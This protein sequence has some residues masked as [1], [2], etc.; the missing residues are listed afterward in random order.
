[1]LE[2]ARFFLGSLLLHLVLLALILFQAYQK[3]PAPY[4]LETQV[5]FEQAAPTK[6]PKQIARD[7]RVTAKKIKTV[8]KEKREPIKKLPKKDGFLRSNRLLESPARQEVESASIAGVKTEGKTGGSLK[9][10]AK[11]WKTKNER[12]AYRGVLSRL[13][14]ANWVLPPVAKKDFQ[15]LIEIFIDP[16]GNIIQLRV[17]QSS[18]LAVLDGAAERAVRVSVPFPKFPASFDPRKKAFRVVFR[19]TSDKIAD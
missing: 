5:V 8:K 7:K 4:Q 6:A 3:I 19:F 10:F 12:S 9:Q 15:V 16:L 1:M 13:V 11:N 14:S 18:G 2:N 17:A